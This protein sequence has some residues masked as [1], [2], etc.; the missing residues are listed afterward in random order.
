[1]VFSEDDKHIMVDKFG[2]KNFNLY[3]LKLE[4]L[5]STKDL[6]EIMEGL[7]TSPSSIATDKIKKIY[8]H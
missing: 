3:K 8:E 7:D 2:G 4:M 1:M 5:L 6:W